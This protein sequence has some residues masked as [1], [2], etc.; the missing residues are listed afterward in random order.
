MLLGITIMLVN[1]INPHGLR[2]FFL[3]E[4]DHEKN[5]GKIFHASHKLR[6]E[7]NSNN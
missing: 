2:H 5:F 3:I 7:V 4:R 1:R 6:T